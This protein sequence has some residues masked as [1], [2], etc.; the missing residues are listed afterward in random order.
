MQSKSGDGLGLIG[1][2]QIQFNEKTIN[3]TQ[4]NKYI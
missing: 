2:S 4:Q 1:F 3:P